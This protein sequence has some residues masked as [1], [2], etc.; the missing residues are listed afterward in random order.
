M[1][2]VRK[3][4]LAENDL[5][6]IWLHTYRKWGEV[7]TDRYLDQ[8]DEGIRQLARYPE[9]GCDCQ[10]VRVDCRGLRVA[11]HVI[12]YTASS[13]SILIVRVLHKRR[14]VSTSRLDQ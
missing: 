11:R 4:A 13:D 5:I 12:Y 10:Y 6:D 7:P 9:L 3:S 1:P 8:L 2:R 14:D